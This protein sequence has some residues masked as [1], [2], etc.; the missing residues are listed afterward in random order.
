MTN[1]SKI[2]PHM[3]IKDTLVE[4]ILWHNPLNAS[5]F[6][7]CGSASLKEGDYARLS[8]SDR[9]LIKPISEA[10]E[11]LSKHSSGIQLKFKT[12]SSRIIVDVKL[13][14]PHDMP[15]M[16]ATGQ[17]GFDLY[18]YDERLNDYVLHN[19]TTYKISQSEYRC[20]LSNFRNYDFGKVEREYIINFPLYQG[21]LDLRIGLEEDAIT[22]PVYFKN[23]G[24]IVVYGTSIAQGGCVTRPGLVY[25]NI[26][27]RWLNM[28]VYNQGYSGSA[29][30]EPIMG[31][32]IGKFPNQKLLVLDAEANAGC[33]YKMRDRL[34]DFVNNYK[35]YQPDV[36]ILFVSRTLFGM[37]R[38]DK[39]RIEL[40]EFY[41]TFVADFIKK[42]QERGHK[43]Y[44]LDGD[45]FFEGFKINYTEFTVDGDHP[46]DFGNYLIAK[47]YYESIEKI[48]K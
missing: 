23:E 22:T 29:L 4:G 39:E 42:Y 35:R 7:L 32:I 45:Q 8:R 17:C 40:K 12:N 11:W 27:S 36:P 16:P 26:L 2:D 46:T 18:V 21:V 28:E 20:E 14:A 37:D 43:M 31:E 41:K 5:L 3:A 30:M 34:E 44:F 47:Y 19:T 6:N 25:T 9:E 15:H 10:V 13:R 33:D 38:Y 24:K 1:I 48:I